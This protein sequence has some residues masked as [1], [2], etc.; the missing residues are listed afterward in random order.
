MQHNMNILGP[1]C[2][3]V[4]SDL[5]YHSAPITDQATPDDWPSLS[6]MTMRYENSQTGLP[7]SIVLPW[8]LQFPVQNERIAGQTGRRMGKCHDAMLIQGVGLGYFQVAGLAT[9]ETATLSRIKNRRRLSNHL[10]IA[11]SQLTLPT[12]LDEDINRHRERAF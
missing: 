12:R 9:D 2:S 3:E 10:P 4:F 8:Y 6:A 11:N 7:P 1:A 5:P